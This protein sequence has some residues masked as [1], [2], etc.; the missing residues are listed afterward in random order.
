MAVADVTADAPKGAKARVT[1]I[2]PRVAATDAHVAVVV[3]AGDAMANAAS[4]VNAPGRVDASAAKPAMPTSVQTLQHRKTHS[5]TAL[6]TT[7]AMRHA[8]S[9]H[10]VVNVVSVVAAVDVVGATVDPK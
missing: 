7:C 9:A 1:A 10:H 4:V 3:A 8:Q 6:M 5:T 2:A